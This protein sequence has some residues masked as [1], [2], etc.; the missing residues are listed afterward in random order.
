MLYLAP[1]NDGVVQ[2]S[3]ARSLDLSKYRIKGPVWEP[4]LNGELAHSGPLA[5]ILRAEPAVEE[6]ATKL[7]HEE[8]S[9]YCERRPPAVLSDSKHLVFLC[10]EEMVS[11]RVL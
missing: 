2:H 8:I 6:A 1:L 7:T 4:D 10:L 3:V 9:A 5:L 11:S